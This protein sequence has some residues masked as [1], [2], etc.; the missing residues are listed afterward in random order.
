MLNQSAKA[1]LINLPDK[2]QPLVTIIIDNYN[3]EEYL[4]DAIK[5]A[6]NQTY[7]NTEIIVVDDGS[8]DNSLSV[9]NN[10]K[11]QIISIVKHNGGQASSLN[12]GFAACHGEIICVLDA[13]DIWLPDKVQTVVEAF[14]TNPNTSIVYHRVQNVDKFCIPKGK[15][16]PAYKAINGNIVN[17]VVTTGGWWPFSPS[18]ALSYRRLFL[19]QVMNIPETEFKICADTYLA[20]LAPFFGDV[21][22]IEKV[23][24]YYRRHGNNQSINPSHIP[25][26]DK[27]IWSIQEHELREKNINRMLLGKGIDIQISLVNNLPYQLTKYKLGYPIDCLNLTRLALENPWENRFYSRL[28]FILLFWLKLFLNIFIVK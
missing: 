26:G 13:D 17:Q 14:N 23:L 6:L 18:S 24:S 1:Q 12:T 2:K 7:K 11:G 25:V 22:G 8:T 20:D 10:F 21:I 16:W 27:E 3:Y 9:I 5:S 19:S 15:P 4:G 28:K